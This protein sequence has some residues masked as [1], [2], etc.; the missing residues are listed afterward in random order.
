MN[1]E[2]TIISIPKLLTSFVLVD[3]GKIISPRL[4]TIREYGRWMQEYFDE[5]TCNKELY[6]MTNK[7]G[8]Q[9]LTYHPGTR[10]GKFFDSNTVERSDLKCWYVHGN[11]S[12]MTQLSSWHIAET[13][14]C[15]PTKLDNKEN[16][17]I[18][19]LYTLSQIEFYIRNTMDK[20]FALTDD[21]V[22]TPKSITVKPED[23]TTLIIPKQTKRK[24]L[25][26]TMKEKQVQIEVKEESK[27]TEEKS[28]K[29]ISNNEKTETHNNRKRKKNRKKNKHHQNNQE[30]RKLTL[31]EIEEQLGYKIQLI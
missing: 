25:L 24:S 26:Q 20:N 17:N 3:K 5:Y 22:H 6:M 31:Q 18:L 1:E 12:I 11:S 7:E 9:V 15:V 29:S 10:I 23:Y 8:G 27:P 16:I 30:P 19:R 2:N 4:T 13:R 28:T 14:D 21:M